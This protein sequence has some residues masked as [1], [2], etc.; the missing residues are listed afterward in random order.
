MKNI[1]LYYPL[2]DA[3]VRMVSVKFPD[4]NN[5]TY[6]YKCASPAIEVGDTVVVEVGDSGRLNVATITKVDVPLP[7]ENDTIVYKWVVQRL[8]MVAHEARLEK[9]QQ[10]IEMVSRRRVENNR[11]ALLGALGLTEQDAR[12]MLTGETDTEEG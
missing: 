12:L 5:K 8:Q 6:V 9:E 1:S 2:V 4:N 11:A 3:N 10:V 7:I